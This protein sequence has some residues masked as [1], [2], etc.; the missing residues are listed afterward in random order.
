MTSLIV[1]A[2]VAFGIWLYFKLINETTPPPK[3]EKKD[4]QTTLF[5]EMKK[6]KDNK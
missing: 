6:L 1:I 3:P 5:R 2:I 4:F